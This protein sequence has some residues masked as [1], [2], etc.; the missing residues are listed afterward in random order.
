MGS[1]EQVIYKA[2]KMKSKVQWKGQEVETLGAKD[3]SRGKLKALR[4][5][6]QSHHQMKHMSETCGQSLDNGELHL[7]FSLLSVCV[8]MY[9]YWKFI[10]FYI[11]QEY[12]AKRLVYVLEDILDIRP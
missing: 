11:L 12:T 10:T 1:P 7:L 6:S 8:C 5:A 2:V 3:V 4:G 9:E